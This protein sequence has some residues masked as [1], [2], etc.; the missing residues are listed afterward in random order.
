MRSSFKVENNLSQKNSISYS[1]QSL[2]KFSSFNNSGG[3]GGG[4]LLYGTQK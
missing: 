3:G 4:A 2:Y 1:K